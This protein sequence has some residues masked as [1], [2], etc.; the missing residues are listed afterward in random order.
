MN[1]KQKFCCAEIIWS[2]FPSKKVSAL[3]AKY[4]RIRLEKPEAF[5]AAVVLQMDDGKAL[6]GQNSALR[7]RLQ[8]VDICVLSRQQ[9]PC[10]QQVCCNAN[11]RHGFK[12]AR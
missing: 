5:F 12:R 3:K 1:A 11:I 8:P 7:Q 10:C 6:Q 2:G 9:Q 4:L